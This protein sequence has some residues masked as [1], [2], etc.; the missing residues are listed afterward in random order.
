MGDL[1]SRQAILKH[2]E[3]TRQS[4]RMMDDIR[5]ASIV[6][7]GMY[8]CEKAVRNQPPERLYTDEEIQKMQEIEQAQ[9]Q[10]A[11]A[12]GRE[13]ALSEIIRCKDCKYYDGRPCGIVDWYN[14]ANDFCSRAQRRT[15]E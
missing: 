5:K 4:A 8:L 12:L 7:N 9:I 6:M 2:I 13:D 15:D 10:K 14:T 11:F 1:I 3:K